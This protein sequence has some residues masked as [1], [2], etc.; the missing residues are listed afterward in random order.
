MNKAREL[1]SKIVLPCLTLLLLLSISAWKGG[2]IGSDTGPQP[3]DVYQMRSL[4]EKTSPSIPSTLVDTEKLED[5]FGDTNQIDDLSENTVKTRS[6]RQFYDAKEQ[7]V[8]V[9]NEDT[10][11]SLSWLY[12]RENIASIL[13]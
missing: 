13:F 8:P 9:F 7:N 12:M 6:K 1:T 3:V 5:K 2:L 4:P 10:D 11:E